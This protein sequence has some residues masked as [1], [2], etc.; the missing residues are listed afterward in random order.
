[1]PIYFVEHIL[2]G[3]ELNNEELITMLSAKG[4]TVK[5]HQSQFITP[6]FL[7]S[8]LS[9][10]FIVSNF[11][12]LSFKAREI[13]TQKCRYIIYEHDHKYLSKRDPAKYKDFKAP[14]N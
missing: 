7:K 2:G 14:Q 11:V 4:H 10:F 13:L 6:Q 9:N 12:N 1:M 5:K 3:G 8:N